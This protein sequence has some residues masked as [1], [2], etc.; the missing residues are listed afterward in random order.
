M[1]CDA[2]GLPV[3]AGDPQATGLGN[4]LVQFYAQGRIKSLEQMRQE[5]ARVCEM[6]E[7][8]PQAE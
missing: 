7:Y 2:A 6:K 8:L 4:L 3:R 1:P 5:A